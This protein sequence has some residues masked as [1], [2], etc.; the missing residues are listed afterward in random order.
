MRFGHVKVKEVFKPD[1]TKDRMAPCPFEGGTGA[2][3]LFT[4]LVRLGKRRRAMPACI[5][6]AR[7]TRNLRSQGYVG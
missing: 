5:E 3:D 7:L 4:I 2:L 1:L 6:Q